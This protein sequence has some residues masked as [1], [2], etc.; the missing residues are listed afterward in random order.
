M[1][2]QWQDERS[3]KRDGTADGGVE[4]TQHAMNRRAAVGYSVDL[5]VGGGR[6]SARRPAKADSSPA[7]TGCRAS[8]ESSRSFSPRTYWP[9]TLPSS[10]ARRPLPSCHPS[11]SLL[12][13]L[14]R[15]RK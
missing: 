5:V 6:E 7:G 3:A 13:V 2:T 8:D 12:V 15:S 9:P 4:V 10:Q 14:G 11:Q 1:W